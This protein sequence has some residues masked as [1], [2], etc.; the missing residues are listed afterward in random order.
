MRRDICGTLV[1]NVPFFDTAAIVMEENIGQRILSK[2]LENIVKKVAS[3]KTLTS[4]ERAIVEQAYGQTEYIDKYAKTV[5]ELADALGVNRK[6]IDRWRKMRNAP[7]VLSDGRHNI[8]KWRDFVKKHGLKEA[9][10]PEDEALKTRKLLADVKQAELKLKVMEGTYVSIERVREVWTQHIGQ[11]RSILESRFLN[12][13]PPIL[14]TLDAIQIRE[15][16]QSV[17]DET[18][19]AISVAAESIKEPVDTEG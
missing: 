16:M 4:A 5:V 11:V 17:L 1:A 15:K 8:A 6:T 7:K 9:D 18:Y 10:T 2:D 12:E 14:T 13:L 3:G 19:K